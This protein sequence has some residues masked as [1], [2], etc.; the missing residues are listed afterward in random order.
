MKLRCRRKWGS[1]LDVTLGICTTL[2]LQL[3]YF[4]SAQPGSACCSKWGL[5]LY[6]S[7][8]TDSKS[9][10]KCDVQ[11]GVLTVSEL[12]PKGTVK[13]SG[14][15][16]CKLAYS[17]FPVSSPQ[18]FIRLKHF[19][20][21]K[22]QSSVVPQRV[23]KVQVSAVPVSLAIKGNGSGQLSPRWSQLDNHAVYYWSKNQSKH[24]RENILPEWQSASHL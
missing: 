14:W 7:S 13:S 18:V 15:I 11:H 24:W 20:P 22:A 19:N 6:V 4:Y 1:F 2:L 16:S 10:Q 23:T 17:G 3:C 5:L 9:L 8:V 21:Q 12:L